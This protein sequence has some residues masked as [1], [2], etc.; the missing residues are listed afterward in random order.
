MNSE[1]LL[2]RVERERKA[3][4]QAEQLLEEKS[5]ALFKSNQELV[6]LTDSLEKQVEQRTHELKQAVREAERANQVKSEFLAR[7]SHEIRTPMNAI[8]GLSHLLLDAPLGAREQD[9]VSK[10]NRS[11]ESLLRLLNDILDF[12]RMESG[13]LEL[14]MMDFNAQDLFRDIHSQLAL[15]VQEKRLDLLLL[16]RESVPEKLQGDALRISQILLNL[17]A[18]AVKFT[19]EGLVEVSLDWRAEAHGYGRLIG[20]VRDTGIGMTREQAAHLFESF[21]QADVS[22]TRKYGGTGLGLAICRQLVE[23]MDGDISVR[24]SPGKGSLFH[25]EVKVKD[26]SSG[27]E[28]TLPPFL[29]KQAAIISDQRKSREVLR[30]DLL[31]LGF[32]VDLLNQSVP[33]SQ[34]KTMQ[35]AAVIVLESGAVLSPAQRNE[36]QQAFLIYLDWQPPAHELAKNEVYLAKPVLRQHLANVLQE[37]FQKRSNS[38]PV[39]PENRRNQQQQLKGLRI[40]SVDDD[41]THQQIIKQRL[42]Q[43]GIQVLLAENGKQALELLH[44]QPVDGV[45]LDLQMPVMNGLQTCRAIRALQQYEKLPILALS[46]H[47]QQQD[48]EASF[49]AGMNDFIA[50]PLDLQELMLKLVIWMSQSEDGSESTQL[51]LRVL[52]STQALLD[53]NHGI[54]PQQLQSVQNMLQSYDTAAEERLRSLLPHALPEQARVLQKVLDELQQYEF[55][56]ASQRLEQLLHWVKQRD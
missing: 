41:S 18:N 36:L 13:K 19:Q 39:N 52:E 6:D 8:I 31:Q 44:Q 34:L 14:E 29:G 10:I 53:L 26:R 45:L 42:S 54:D 25:F 30:S 38:S 16:C 3:R 28:R 37:Q 55:D 32:Q 12:S 2:R 5:L 35:K 20:D 17:V 24:S 43:Q 22:T 40:L 4:K 21:T 23:M 9:Y 1:L 50:K 47:S 46:A 48:R 7:M 51:D 15:R 11:A 27:E 33:Q 56:A 49:E